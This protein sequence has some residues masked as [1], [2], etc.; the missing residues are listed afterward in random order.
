MR[1]YGFSTGSSSRSNWKSGDWI[2]T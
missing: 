2:C 1:G